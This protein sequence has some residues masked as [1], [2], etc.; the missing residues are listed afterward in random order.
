MVLGWRFLFSRFRHFSSAVVLEGQNH[1]LFFL[2]ALATGA[3]VSELISL[4]REEIAILFT[5]K[6]V[7]LYPNP[8]FLAKNENPKF[9]KFPVFISKLRSEV[10][11][12]HPLCQ[13]R[14]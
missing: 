9:R 11:V 3:R 12:P 6:G 13:C 7:T 2:L 4:L 5:S 1:G 14:I 10:G 8:N